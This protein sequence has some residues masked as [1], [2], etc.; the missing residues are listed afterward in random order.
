MR[1]LIIKDLLNL[2]KYF[3]M[4][5]LLL[6]STSLISYTSDNTMLLMLLVVLFIPLI[7]IESLTE[8]ASAQWDRLALA[9]PISRK[10]IVV[11]KYLLL[12]ILSTLI[13][14]T[15]GLT[16]IIM[17]VKNTL[18]L[19]RLWLISYGGFAMVVL[20]ISVSIPFIYKFGI[21]KT[22]LLSV[23]L[24]AIPTIIGIVIDAI[25]IALPSKEQLMI[26]LKVSP[27]ILILCLLVSIEISYS[28]Y[29]KK[30]I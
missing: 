21:E 30:D 4:I 14:P 25:D 20:L 19:S 9:M 23:I 12:I 2:R 26:L 18:N 22:R 7:V 16:F 10:E 5:I 15:T 13:I 28:I 29:R 24:V 11:S 17:Y 1:G 27:I 3:N 8:D 6:A